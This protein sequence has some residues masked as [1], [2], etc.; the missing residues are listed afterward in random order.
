MTKKEV[1]CP[2]YNKGKRCNKKLCEADIVGELQAIC[3]RCRK[4]FT[5]RDGV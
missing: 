5:W 4:P 3:S 1:R 2:N